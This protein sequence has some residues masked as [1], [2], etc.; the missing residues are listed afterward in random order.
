LPI[1][2]IAIEGNQATT[3]VTLDEIQ[4]LAKTGAL[5]KFLSGHS[6]LFFP[7]KRVTGSANEPTTAKRSK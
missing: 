6:A 2:T 1:I 7:D 5:S 4:Q 3:A